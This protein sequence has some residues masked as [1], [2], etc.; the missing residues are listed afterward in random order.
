MVGAVEE[1]KK[2][3][4][5]LRLQR[6]AEHL[7]DRTRRGG[8]PSTASCSGAASA[9]SENSAAP[10]MDFDSSLVTPAHLAQ[11]HDEG[12]TVLHG[13]VGGRWLRSLQGRFDE[14]VAEEGA[15]AGLDGMPEELRNDVLTGTK[16]HPNPGF[17]QLGDVVN[18][19]RVFDGLWTHP[20]LLKLVAS[21]LPDF[22][23]FSLNSLD[24][25]HGQGQ[26]GLHRDTLAG[27]EPSRNFTIVNSVWMLDDFD[28][29]NGATRY[30]PQ[31][32]IRAN[33][34][35]ERDVRFAA[36]P[37]GSVL[38]FNGS[39]LHGASLNRSGARRRG[40]HCAW[41]VRSKPQ[42]TDQLRCLRRSTALRLTPLGRYLLDVGDSHGQ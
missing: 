3:A 13:V 23:L 26:Q 10:N 22:K 38:V 29:S 1:A 14:I 2:I 18:K 19:G 27:P 9:G 31:S 6:V 21:V 39:L 4:P 36:A 15:L 8:G 30:V 40:L 11:L 17:R 5:M 41:V 35:N 42:Q 33:T 28:E 20:A 37:A 32:H 12:F 34:N 7:H 24:P 16:Q 25:K